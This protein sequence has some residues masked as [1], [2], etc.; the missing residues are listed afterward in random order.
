MNTAVIDPIVFREISELMDDSLPVFIQTYLDNTLNL[1]AQLTQT[2]LTGDKEAIFHDAH[3]LKGG[4]GS[5]GAMQVCN[6]A[7]QMEVIAKGSDGVAQLSE[8]LVELKD[9]FVA[10]E[11]ELKVHL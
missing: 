7:E 11:A 1:L 2:V 8:L 6:I 4:S 3:Q 5:I 10:V 9:A